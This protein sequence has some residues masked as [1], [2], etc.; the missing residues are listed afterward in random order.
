LEPFE[1]SDKILFEEDPAA[2]RLGPRD[3]SRLGTP[4]HRVLVHMQK[5]RGLVDI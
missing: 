1:I 2:A 4:L 5:S 3:L